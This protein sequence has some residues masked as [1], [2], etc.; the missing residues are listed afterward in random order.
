MNPIER[1]AAQWPSHGRPGACARAVAAGALA[2]WA[3]AGPGQ[4][5]AQHG[6]DVAF[7]PPMV[8]GLTV[9][10]CAVWGTNCGWGGAH[11]FCQAQGYAAARSWQLNRPGR[12]YVIGANRVCEGSQCVGFSQ[13]VC[14]RQAAARPP[15]AQPAQSASQTA[16]LT[17]RLWAWTDNDYA[18]GTLSFR[19]DGTAQATWAPS[20]AF[21]WQF[22]SASQI[23]VFADGT[24]WV[25][26]L[27]WDGQ[28]GVFVG[29][30]D[31]QSQV[32]DN[33]R[34]LVRP[35]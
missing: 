12:T 30:R 33:V 15:Q 24:R 10:N 8:H 23:R 17:G 5:L 18:L 22:A 19:P 20:M 16:F 34:H 2:L 1:I 3:L 13:V 31:P 9:D 6:P 14:V 27:T 32:Q 26:L 25:S 28:R 11:Q 21:R 29:G 4:A 35:N 7:T